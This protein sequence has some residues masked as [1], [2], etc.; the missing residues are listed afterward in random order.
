MRKKRITL[1]TGAG[2]DVYHINNTAMEELAKEFP[3]SD[4]SPSAAIME[5][6]TMKRSG[7]PIKMSRIAVEELAGR[8]HGLGY[9]EEL[10]SMLMVM[11]ELMEAASRKPRMIKMVHDEFGRWQAQELKKVKDGDNDGI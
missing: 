8:L 7:S 2:S 3:T 6:I 5:L 1:Q 9:A 10:T 11:L 4:Y